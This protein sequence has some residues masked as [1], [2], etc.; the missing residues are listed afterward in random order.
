MAQCVNCGTEL[1][2]GIKFC[3]ACG[4]MQPAEQPVQQPVQQQYEQPVQQTYQQQS[5]QQQSYQQQAY[6]QQAYQQQP[7]QQPV[8]PV[9]QPSPDDKYRYL[10]A[11]SYLSIFA[12][13]VLGIF[14]G[15][16]S[17]YFRRHANQVVALY[18]WFLACSVV[19][20]IPILGWIVGG[21]GYIAGIVFM[22]M[23]IVKAIKCVDYEIPVFGKVKIIP[24]A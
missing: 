5:Y 18:I 6:Q 13:I 17:N 3:P 1:G 22:I 15:K 4:T 2:V 10:A 7:Y 16:D 12:L 19:M 11:L 8:Q 23:A 24:E 21:I 20:I 14:A 9:R